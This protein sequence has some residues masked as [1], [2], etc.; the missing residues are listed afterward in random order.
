MNYAEIIER[1]DEILSD[2]DEPEYDHITYEDG[3]TIAMC[4]HRLKQKDIG[5]EDE[6]T[7]FDP[8][9]PDKPCRCG[10]LVCQPCVEMA[11]AFDQLEGLG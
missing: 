2:D 6:H 1:V 9:F 8:M 11:L 3:D 4:G 5:T 10:R 7:D